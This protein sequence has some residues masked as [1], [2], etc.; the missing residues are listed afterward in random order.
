MPGAPQG[1]IS[2][3][4]AVVAGRTHD[5]PSLRQPTVGSRGHSEKAVATVDDT[6]AAAHAVPL[7]ERH[8]PR[9]E[10]P[11][12]VSISDSR[13]CWTA[14]KR[15]TENGLTIMVSGNGPTKMVSEKGGRRTWSHKHGPS[16]KNG[17]TKWSRKMVSEDGL[18]KMVS[19]NGLTEMV[20]ENRL[21]KMVSQN[22]PR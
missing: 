6:T 11:A 17:R 14:P 12:W 15:T 1:P 19:E 3:S 9:T 21:T 18:T 7:R 2:V 5:F 13:K 22:G 8:M 10:D 20:S 4:Y 16:Q